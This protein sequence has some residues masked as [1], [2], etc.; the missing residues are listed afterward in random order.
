L[1]LIPLAEGHSTSTLVRRA[2]ERAVTPHA[3]ESPPPGPHVG[4]T[5]N[6][7]KPATIIRGKVG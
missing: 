6:A 2:S 5:G 4:R 7:A 1:V 3:T